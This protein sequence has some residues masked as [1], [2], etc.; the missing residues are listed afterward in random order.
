MQ[1]RQIKIGVIIA[2]SMNRTEKLFC[3]SLASVLAQTRKPD[4]ILVVDDNEESIVKTE[5]KNKIQKKNSASNCANIFYIENTHT[6]GMSGTG[7]W[8]SAF[9]WYKN[10]LAEDD[11]VAVLDDDDAWEKTYLEKCEEKIL[12]AKKLPDEV[13]AFIKRSDCERPNF[14][15]VEDL[16]VNNFLIGN[17]GVQGSNMFFKFSSVLEISGF[18]ENLSS[19]T[20]RDF[21]VRFLSQ[22]P[23][24]HIEI[25]KE[26][27]VNHFA[28]EGTVTYDLN[29]K[30][31]GLDGFYKKFINLY[32][33]DLLLKSLGRAQKLFAYKNAE[34]IYKLWR[35]V[36]HHTNDEKIVVGVALHNNAGTVRNAVESLLIQK[37]LKSDLWL[38]LVDDASCDNWQK[39]ISDLLKK[40]NIVYWK[41][42]FCNVSATRNFINNFIKEYFG[43]VKLIGRLDSDDVYAAETV[44]AKIEALKDETN[45]DVIFAGNYLK[46]NG[47]ILEKVNYASR[48]LAK[49]KYLLNRLKEMAEGTAENEL[50]S[51][52][53][54]ITFKSLTD[55]PDTK[56]AE[57]H[58]VTAKL[59]WNERNLKLAFAEDVLLTVYSLNGNAT[60]NNKEQ[61]IY[62]AARKMLYEEFLRY[63]Q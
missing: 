46:L 5:I 62:N 49:R 56:S 63:D 11:Y 59:L 18:D 35:L 21:M 15:S 42:N 34:N 41:V 47:Q 48:E 9:E 39:E 38:L 13:V 28:G 30:E 61:H 60:A 6:K 25:V 20:D 44:L 40:E 53:T 19:C 45:A 1:K 10:Y 8:N 22:K 52:N 58:F 33:E 54:F 24:P 7:A 43:N 16:S 2:T 50:P 51:C 57:D 31:K 37:K 36:N 14:F 26:V 4:F 3:I 23:K 27:L 55:Y 32:T 17:P 29:K 12:S